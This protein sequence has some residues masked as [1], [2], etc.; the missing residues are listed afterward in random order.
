MAETESGRV[1][2]HNLEAEISFLGSALLD[3]DVLGHAAQFLKPEDFFSPQH[4]ILF[5]TLLGLYDRGEAV[6]LVLL[7]NALQRDGSL[8]K[9]GGVENLVSIAESVPSSANGS[10][11]A[12]IVRDKAVTRR[13]IQTTTD[14]LREAYREGREADELLDHAEQAIFQVRGDEGASAGLRIGDIL[15]ETF[16]KIDKMHERKGR[17]EGL[18][19]GFHDL[20]DMTAGLL[21]SQLVVIAGRPSM[22]KTSFALTVAANIALREEKAVAI[23]S[24]ETSRQQIAEN[25]LC[26]R[27]GV[28]AHRLRKG[29]IREEEWPRL[30]DAAGRLSE[31]MIFIDDTPG[32][33]P[34]ALKAKARRLKARHGIEL[35]VLDYLQLMESSMPRS[36]GRQ[37][38]ISH[39][40]RSLKGIARELEIPVI[41]LS[42]LNRSVDARED[43]RPRLS[44]LRESGAIEQDADLILFLFRE[45]YYDPTDENRGTAEVLVAKQRNGPTGKVDLRFRAACLRFENPTRPWQQGEDFPSD[46]A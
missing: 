16:E 19:T 18:E 14:V 6:D 31:A 43:H 9:V 20:D 41:A 2:P 28:D 35:V 11:Y 29:D 5:R 15:K 37:Q 12:R 23:Y 42:Q 46:G 36:E 8:E 4:Q 22:G 38:E 3:A 30:T 1:P 24:L 13:L 32:L 26:Q 44:D 7:K 45:E 33:S 27:A 34:L 40:S 17:L 21:S 39:I 25:L 10:F